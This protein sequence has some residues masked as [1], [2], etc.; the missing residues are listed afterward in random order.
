VCGGP[1]LGIHEASINVQ[2]QKPCRSLDFTTSWCLKAARLGRSTT[3]RLNL[4]AK[5]VL[6]TLE[7]AK[8]VAMAEGGDVGKLVRSDYLWTE[9][10][11]EEIVAKSDGGGELTSTVAAAIATAVATPVANAMEPF[12]IELREYRQA[13]PVRASG[14]SIPVLQHTKRRKGQVPISV[15]KEVKVYA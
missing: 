8:R 12:M 6:L 3:G 7:S 15:V 14:I 4:K 2:Y 13:S 9:G 1:D 10:V 11:V 5:V